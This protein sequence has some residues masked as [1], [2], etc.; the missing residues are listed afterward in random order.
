MTPWDLTTSRK[1]LT[2]SVV[3]MEELPL[4]GDEPIMPTMILG[5]M[6]GGVGWKCLRRAVMG[7][8]DRATLMEGVVAVV[9]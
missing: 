7:A 5:D 9:G 6:V 3:A 4:P 8:F 1:D 2:W